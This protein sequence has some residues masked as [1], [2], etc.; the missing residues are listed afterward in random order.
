MPDKLWLGSPLSEESSKQQETTM[1]YDKVMQQQEKQ[2]GA[3]KC[4]I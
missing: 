2:F 4:G 3:A 1:V